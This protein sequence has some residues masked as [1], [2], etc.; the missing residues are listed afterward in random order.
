MAYRNIRL[1]PVLRLIY[2]FLRVLVW[3][4]VRVFYRRRLV[5]GREYFR[6][7]GPA[8]V[9]INH[10]STLMDVLNSAVEI[11][12]EMFFLA[13]YGLFRHPLSNWLLTRLFCIPVKR[14]EDV[15]EGE[16]RN[17][18]GAFEASYRHLEKNGVLFIA[19]EGVSWMNRFV[20][21]IKTGAA[22]IALGAEAHNGWNLDVKIIPIGLSYSTPHLFR[23]DVV[24]QA[25][26]PVYA[27]EWS[28]NWQKNPAQ[29]AKDLTQYL[30]DQ[31][32]ALSIHT[33]DEAGEALIT[34]LEE[35]LQNENPL[36]QQA[37][38]ERSQR[39]THTVL[40]NADL[41]EKTEAYFALLNKHGLTDRGICDLR[42]TIYD[43]RLAIYD[44]R[45]VGLALGFPVFAAVYV[46]WFLPCY[47]PWLLNKK[48]GLYIGYSSTV[49]IVAGM[50]TFPLALWGWY[51]LA[52]AAGLEPVW[53]WA[54]LVGFTALGFFVDVY[55]DWWRD[56]RAARRVRRVEKEQP[57]VV[58]AIRKMRLEITVLI[59]G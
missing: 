26:E 3:I 34:R 4:S 11:R 21:P 46:F 42:F 40:D 22:R 33:R 36:P 53:A 49:K 30:E 16:N 38:F 25:G 10:P 43:W 50:I 44:W 24:V 54:V 15:A 56:W 28:E 47:L 41:R 12:Q 9:I 7:D 23:S 51:R 20:R 2:L 35:L 31:L 59:S 45:L 18:D 48:M 19:V 17:N 5:L 14:K 55:Q 8:I 37:A 39:L 29:A 6:F 1:H 52:L 13:N 58:A 32:K 27:R 57:E